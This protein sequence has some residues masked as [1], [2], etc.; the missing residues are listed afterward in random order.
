[1]PVRG[2]CTVKLPMVRDR[3]NWTIRGEI[4]HPISSTVN[5]D[6]ASIPVGVFFFDFAGM[7]KWTNRLLGSDRMRLLKV[8][9]D[10]QT[11]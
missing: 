7:R 9:N 4:T 10:C 6:Q 11:K 2:D 3:S 1:M 5:S 8:A